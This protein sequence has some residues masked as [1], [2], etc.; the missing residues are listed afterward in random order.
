[1]KKLTEINVGLELHIFKI[2]GNGFLVTKNE[3]RLGKCKM[4]SSLGFISYFM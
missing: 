4:I 2:E 1:M 3:R